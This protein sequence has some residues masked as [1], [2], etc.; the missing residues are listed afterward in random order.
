MTVREN[1]L[2]PRKIRVRQEKLKCFI[3]YFKHVIR[4]D[5]FLKGNLRIQR[6]KTT[7][8]DFMDYTKMDI[9][10]PLRAVEVLSLK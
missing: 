8:S 10:V 4:H 5:N 2:N 7:N 1:E 6:T 9:E 3:A